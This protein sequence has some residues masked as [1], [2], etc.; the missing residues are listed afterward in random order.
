MATKI[1]TKTGDDGTTGLFGGARLPKHHI[2]IDAYG[3]V[4]EF[5]SVIGWLMTFVKDPQT[6]ELLL[7]IQSRLFTVGSNLAS[8]PDKDMITPDLVDDDIEMIE[9]AIDKMQSVL[10]ELKHFILPGGSQS[11]SAAHLARTVCRR[12]ER[13]CVALAHE[14]VIEPMILLYLNR[15]SDYFFVLARWLGQVEGVEEIKW[16]PRKTK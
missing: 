5:N 7:I 10:P 14:S 13:K 2:R 6:H 4:D 16:V 3:T 15:L 12:A 1:Y 11:V 8:D 9:K